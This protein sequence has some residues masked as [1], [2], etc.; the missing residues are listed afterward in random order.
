MAR[1]K[2]NVAS[3]RRKK[4]IFKLAKGQRGA[5]RKLSRT[6]QESMKRALAYSYRDRRAK[7][8]TFRRLWI[9]RINAACKEHGISY[10]QFI[11]GL[12]QADV[13]VDRKILAEIARTDTKAFDAIVK[14]AQ[15]KGK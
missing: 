4:K 2:T 9:V 7:K 8:R 12:K 1:V 13:Q 5:R 15:K 11:N 14:A 10:S 3:R 6:A